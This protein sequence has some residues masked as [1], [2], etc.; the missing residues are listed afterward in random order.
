[1]NDRDVFRFKQLARTHAKEY[2]TSPREIEMELDVD[3][4]TRDPECEILVNGNTAALE[5][6]TGSCSVALDRFEDQV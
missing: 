6:G 3:G 4:G 5:F 2:G 1:M